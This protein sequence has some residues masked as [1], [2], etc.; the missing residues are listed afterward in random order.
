MG[1]SV[2]G[3]VSIIGNKINVTYR[4]GS[5]HS[6]F[7]MSTTGHPLPVLPCN[8]HN[9]QEC[10]I[11]MQLC[12][13]D[14]LSHRRT[15]KFINQESLTV[16]CKDGDFYIQLPSEVLNYHK[17]SLEIAFSP[18]GPVGPHFLF[19]TGMIPVSPAVWLCFSPNRVFRN[20][21]ILKMPHCFDR[22]FKMSLL[23]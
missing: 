10:V 20:P 18:L 1:S 19:P 14:V 9:F 21:A 16:T 7:S 2:F 11:G 15:F 17:P 13:E 22:R 4:A 8:H 3:M 23:S 5:K 6:L 12:S